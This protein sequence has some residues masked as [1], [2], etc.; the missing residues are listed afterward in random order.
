MKQPLSISSEQLKNFEYSNQIEWLVTNGLG[1]YASQTALGVNTRKYHGLLIAAL[2]PP[3]ERTV[4]LSKI[5]EEIT[6]LTQTY[7][8]STNE[9]ED[10]TYP[11]GYRFQK[12]FSVSPFP[13]FFYSTPEFELEKTVFMP[14]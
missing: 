2:Q 6:T 13:T 9:F 14:K 4:C 10:V 3:G 8:L 11:Q 5:E 12:S 7:Q 1:G